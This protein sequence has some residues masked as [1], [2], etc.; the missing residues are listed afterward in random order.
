MT[1]RQ[2]PAMRWPGSPRTSRLRVRERRIASRV[3]RS[4]PTTSSRPPLP[5]AT[6]TGVETPSGPVGAS[7]TAA[8]SGEALG[9]AVGAGASDGGGSS[10]V[11]RKSSSTGLGSS[12]GRGSGSNDTQPS[13]SKSTSGQAYAS[14]ASTGP[15][16]LVRKPTT[17]RVGSPESRPRTAKAAA[18]CSEVPSCPP[19]LRGPNRKKPRFGYACPL[20]ASA[21]TR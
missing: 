13:P 19:P 11:G 10:G 16:P 17:T 20:G 21:T 18:N 15:C 6:S 4:A 1:S 5:P 12:L 8:G 14:P 7:A 3:S 9:S 2:A